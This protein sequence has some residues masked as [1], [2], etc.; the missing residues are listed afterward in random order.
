MKT[1]LIPR[2]SEMRD[3]LGKRGR[4][5]SLLPAQVILGLSVKQRVF[6]TSDVEHHRQVSGGDTHA[7]QTALG[8]N[9][10]QS[11]KLFN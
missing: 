8:S 9:I 6:P 2:L 4:F 7:L 10:L 3:E 5:W 1:N 11:Q